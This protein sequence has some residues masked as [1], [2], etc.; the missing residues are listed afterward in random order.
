MVTNVIDAL[1]A[2]GSL[3]GTPP[4]IAIDAP[5]AGTVR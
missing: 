1:L 5:L 4:C 3:S 2:A